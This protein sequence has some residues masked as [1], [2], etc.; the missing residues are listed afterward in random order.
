MDDILTSFDE[1]KSSYDSFATSL[2]S[3]LNNLLLNNDMSVHSIESRVKERSS[4]ELK[5]ARK[6]K[7]KAINEVTDIVGVRIITHYSDDVDKVASIIEREFSID[8]NNSIDKR[9]SLEP[10]RFGYLSLH[11]IVSLN[12]SRANLHEHSKYNNYKAEIQIRT[13]LQHA[14]AEIEHD[15]G[16]KSSTGLPNEIKRRFSRLSGLLEIADSEFLEIKKNI[17]LQKEKAKEEIKSG[18]KNIAINK[19]TLPEYIDESEQIDII[20]ESISNKEYLISTPHISNDS[21]DAI[22]AGLDYLKISTIDQLDELIK[23][24]TPSIIARLENMTPNLLKIISRTI[25]IRGLIITHLI[26]NIIAYQNN[27]KIEIEYMNRITSGMSGKDITDLFSAI[28]SIIGTQV[29]Q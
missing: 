16:Y 10:D 21:M 14:W 13:I 27:K 29:V 15:L 28:R 1:K 3:L 6:E 5:I 8:Q 24:H 4:L 18:E 25:M 2:K 20:L 19:I 9:A 11:Y 23:E 7:Y 12:P 22:L 26:Q 17:E